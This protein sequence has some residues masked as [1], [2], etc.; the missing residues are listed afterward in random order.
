MQ[1]AIKIIRTF[2]IYEAIKGPSIKNARTD[3]GK[4]A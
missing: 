4:D 3:V 1:R 2:G